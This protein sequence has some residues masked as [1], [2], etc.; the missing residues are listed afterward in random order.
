MM[1]VAYGGGGTLKAPDLNLA[2][3]G[4]LTHKLQKT[5]RTEKHVK[6]YHQRSCDENPDQ[7]TPQHSFS[8]VARLTCGPD[9]PSL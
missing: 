3:A 2:K 4:D 1:Y 5:Q 7:E 8:A 6:W 9:N